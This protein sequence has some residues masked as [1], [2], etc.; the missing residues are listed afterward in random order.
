MALVR[1]GVRN[2]GSGAMQS[3][4]TRPQSLSTSAPG[5]SMFARRRPLWPGGPAD[6]PVAS[7]RESARRT[8]AA[9][10]AGT[11]GAP[12]SSGV[13]S[14]PVRGAA[15]S[16]QAEDQS[17]AQRSGPESH[18]SIGVALTSAV[19][20]TAIGRTRNSKSATMVTAGAILPRLAERLGIMTFSVACGILTELHYS[21]NRVR[22]CQS[23]ERSC[24][25]WVHVAEF[26]TV[27]SPPH[28]A[29]RSAASNPFS[30]PDRTPS[31]CA[32]QCFWW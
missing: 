18:G 19:G 23:K 7:R 21:D 26:G 28:V 29:R 16:Q 27:D 8:I 13:V 15:K 1:R 5:P 32:R 3:G 24:R 10:G 17:P 20:R 12:G 6:F 22:Y 2:P 31:C 4:S 14:R 25:C 30:Q 11:M 9:L